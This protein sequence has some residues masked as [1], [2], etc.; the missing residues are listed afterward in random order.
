[1]EAKVYLTCFLGNNLNHWFI[2]QLDDA[3]TLDLG[4]TCGAPS[5]LYVEG[6]SYK[7][8]GPFLTTLWHFIQ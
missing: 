6:Q 7:D 2:C 4:L 8:E 5:I 1:M 3:Q